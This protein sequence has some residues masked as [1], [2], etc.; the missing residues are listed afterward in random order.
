MA[1]IAVVGAGSY[2]TCLAILT[3]NAGHD[4][5]LWARE[6]EVAAELER[7]RENKRYLPGYTLP[8]N[9]RITSDLPSALA[10]KEIVLGVTPS[11]AIASVFEPAA[12]HLDPDA[13]V[14]NASKGLEEQTLDT[15][16]QIYT[17]IFSARIAARA[18][19]LSGPTFA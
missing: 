8:A 9:V 2:G 10:T 7:T 4:V 16:D 14:V 6:P 1:Q 18:T 3:A 11:H 13:I 5:T 19:F 15:I 12:S 17:R